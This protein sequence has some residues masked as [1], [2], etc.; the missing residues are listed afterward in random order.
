MP[1]AIEVRQ[2]EVVVVLG[3]MMAEVSNMFTMGMNPCVGLVLWSPTMCALGHFHDWETI[4]QCG[5][6]AERFCEVSSTGQR[7]AVIVLAKGAQ[8]KGNAWHSE[9]MKGDLEK[10]VNPLDVEVVRPAP[11]GEGAKVKIRL[12]DGK[13]VYYFAYEKGTSLLRTP[14]EDWTAKPQAVAFLVVGVVGPGPDKILYVK[15]DQ[16]VQLKLALS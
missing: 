16:P 3:S 13:L 4:A 8:E 7:K 6:V 9:A 11:S 10:L 5:V 2:N 14:A 15:G 12:K 1:T